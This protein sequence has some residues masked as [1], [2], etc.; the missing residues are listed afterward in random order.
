MKIS[1]GALLSIVALASVDGHAQA[2]SVRGPAGVLELPSEIVASVAPSNPVHPNIEMSAVITLVDAQAEI[3]GET[4]V[5]MSCV[6]AIGQLRSE[7][8]IER[9]A[10]VTLQMDGLKLDQPSE[11]IEL[12]SIRAYRTE[13]SRAQI[14]Q[15]TQWMIPRGDR[16]AWIK[17][18]RPRGSTMEQAVLNAVANMQITCGTVVSDV[19]G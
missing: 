16:F 10:A 15:L 6:P 5:Q 1:R 18:D 12:D 4:S 8:G 7:K 3:P 9:L 13:A 19:D 2:G 17:F 11:W 14:S